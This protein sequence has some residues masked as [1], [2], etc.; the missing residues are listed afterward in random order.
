MNMLAHGTKFAPGLLRPSKMQQQVYS[1]FFEK[2]EVLSSS[3]LKG[4]RNNQATKVQTSSAM[5]VIKTFLNP[6]SRQMRFE[7]EVS[8]LNHCKN[9]GIRSVPEILQVNSET[10]SILQ[11]F[12]DGKKPDALTDFHFHEAAKFI[13]TVNNGEV[14][15]HTEFIEA[16]EALFD[17]QKLFD[18][19]SQRSKL[20]RVTNIRSVVNESILIEVESLIEKLLDKRFSILPSLN[21]LIK[22]S[23]S[24][25]RLGFISPSDFG[26]HNS[27]ETLD[28]LFF[29]D[30]EYSGL[31]SPVKLILDFIFQPDYFIL[32]RDANYFCNQ[33]GEIYGIEFE[34][35]K[36]EIRLLFAIKWFLIVL[37]R[38]SPEESSRIT[39]QAVENYYQTRL[40][41]LV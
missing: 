9:L 22:S 2:N 17:G 29:I 33:I 39:Q 37:K 14:S 41:P 7:K 20:L 6:A 21:S 8:F 35:I 11:T 3:F 15:S 38:V 24:S 1:P 19:I 30:F 16:T 12:V 36:R 10:F 32:E 18:D 26:F 13:R 25:D 34:D 4:G 28:G 23:L 5:Y 31:D 27:I 40:L